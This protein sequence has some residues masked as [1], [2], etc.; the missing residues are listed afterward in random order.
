MTDGATWRRWAGIVAGVFLGAVLL[1]AAL[2]KA[3]DPHSFAEQIRAHGLD[4]LAPAGFL[5][6][7]ALFL[8]AGLG[9]SLLVG[10]RRLVV[11]LPTAALVLFF[12]V[13]TGRAAW[14]DVSAAEAGCGC[15]GNV[16]DRSPEEA[17]WQ[18]LVLLVPPLLLA[19]L[20]RRDEAGRGL[21]LRFV[22]VAVGTIG[23]L[24]LAWRA[25]E[26]P[27]DDL[28]TR[29]RPDVAVGELCAGSDPRV[30]LS[31]VAPDLQDGDHWVVILDLEA[32]TPE[33]VENLNE[34]VLSEETSPLL[35]LTAASEE[36][37]RRFTWESGPAF[38]IRQ[39]PPALLSAMHRRL[40]RSFRV[41]GGVVTETYAGLAPP[42]RGESS[43]ERH[44]KETETT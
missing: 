27:L 40:P 43:A 39:A 34:Y 4:A 5:V 13:L 12:L 21:G 37:L 31:E 3:I 44:L 30:C 20:G 28:A 41:D 1:F 25:P 8:E 19:F 7:I 33:T 9:L 18:D 22:A 36:E 2:T 38:S 23:V 32:T 42:L 35:A 10:I 24:L 17:F 11:L 16:V 15:F 14:G 6:A 29:L 26:L